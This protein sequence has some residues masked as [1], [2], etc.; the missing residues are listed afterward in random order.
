MAH[1]YLS[2]ELVAPDGKF[3][4]GGKAREDISSILELDGAAPIV[5]SSPAEDR[6]TLSGFGKVHAHID[7]Y[8]RWSTALAPLVQGD[9]IVIQVPAFDH[10]ILFGHLLARLKNRGIFTILLVHDLNYL[11][12]PEGYAGQSPLRIKG[13]ELSSLR[14]CSVAIVHNE[15]MANKLVSADVIGREKLITLGIFDYLASEQD[16]QIGARSLEL[17]IVVAGNLTREKAGYLYCLPDNLKFD[18]FG[19]GYEEVGH[20]NLSYKGKFM[21]NDIPEM[22]ASFGLVWD[23]PSASTCAGDFGEYLRI[24]NPHKTSL[25]LSAGLPVIIWEH[26]ALANFIL[27][28]NAGFVVSNLSEIRSRIDHM[29]TSEYQSMCDNARK[30]SSSLRAGANTRSAVHAA[31]E[32]CV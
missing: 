23:G 27:E 16:H 29:A 28:N 6:R 17:P 14:E 15:A 18:L 19:A 20:S 7:A 26:A 32:M 1:Y 10:T 31:Y 4:A 25:Y 22:N 5:L 12:H 2:E 8:R 30:L 3:N 24:N 11:R 13:E 21:P 9:T